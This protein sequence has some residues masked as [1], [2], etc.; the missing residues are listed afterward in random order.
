MHLSSNVINLLRTTERYG[1][2][3]SGL[4]C[5]PVRG[6]RLM[7]GSHVRFVR[8]LS[9]N[10]RIFGN[11]RV[12]RVLMIDD[13]QCGTHRLARSIEVANLQP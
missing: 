6:C 5:L 9:F 10:D 8:A 11:P 3:A 13:K 12:W 1:Y 7:Y 4:E 2:T